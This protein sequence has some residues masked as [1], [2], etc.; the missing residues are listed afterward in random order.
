[1]SQDAVERVL[2]RMLT[3]CRFRTQVAQ[4]LEAACRQEGFLLNSVELRLLSALELPRFDELARRLD[5][6]LCRAAVVF[7]QNSFLPAAK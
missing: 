2:G 5:P 4:S 1:M 3:D 7:D 6:E